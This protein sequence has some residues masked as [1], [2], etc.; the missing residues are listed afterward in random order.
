M[1]TYGGRE[2][3]ALDAEFA[4]GGEYQ[5]SATVTASVLPALRYEPRYEDVWGA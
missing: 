4:S 5:V 3:K 2:D 1:K